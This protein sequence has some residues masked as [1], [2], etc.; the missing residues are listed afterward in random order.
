MSGFLVARVAQDHA[1]G[2]Q[3]VEVAFWPFILGH[4]PFFAIL[5]IG[6]SPVGALILLLL[7]RSADLKATWNLVVLTAVPAHFCK[8]AVNFREELTEEADQELLLKLEHVGVE[9]AV[10]VAMTFDIE[11]EGASFV[12]APRLGASHDF[13]ERLGCFVEAFVF[14]DDVV[15]GDVTVTDLDLSFLG[16]GH[17]VNLLLAG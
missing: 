7:S 11:K 14:V 15:Q 2:G 9:A 10:L 12:R 17:P 13:K 8:R 6:V 5:V 16:I 1:V 4:R 3:S